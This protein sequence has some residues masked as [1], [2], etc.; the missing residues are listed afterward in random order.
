MLQKRATPT[1]ISTAG[2]QVFYRFTVT[3]AGTVTIH[4]LVVDDVFTAP[5][6]PELTPTCAQTTLAS[7][8]STTCSAT[9]VATQADIDNGVINNTATVT[10]LDP[11]NTT[12]TSNQST[13][14]VVVQQSSSLSLTK[15][16]DP[17]TVDHAGQPITYTF[18][19]VNTGNVTIA[20]LTINDP[21]LP[22]ADTPVCT[23]TTLAPR[24]ECDLY[25]DL[26]RHPG[27]PRPWLDHEHRC[28]PR[29]RPVG[30]SGELAAVE[31]HRR[32]HAEP[33]GSPS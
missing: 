14:A 21:P 8:A 33:A 25:G 17:T 20:G 13:A 30:R 19:V 24:R 28:G 26:R 2:Q 18:A 16:A 31:R 15:T 9:Y 32:R 1:Q 27:R 7:G 22:R 5:A 4:G 29:A 23:P 10:G 11:G 3:N 6:G 12:V